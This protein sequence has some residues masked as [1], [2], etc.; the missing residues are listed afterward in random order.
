MYPCFVVYDQ[1]IRVHSEAGIPD[2]NFD[3][4]GDISHA[5]Q[6][7][8]AVRAKRVRESDHH[9]TLKLIEITHQYPP[10]TL[11]RCRFLGVGVEP[12]VYADTPGKAI[13]YAA[14]DWWLTHGQSKGV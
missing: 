3:P 2:F 6:I 14:Y 10:V 11:W 7:A 12:W 8:N 4:I 13:C 1:I 9:F 5:W